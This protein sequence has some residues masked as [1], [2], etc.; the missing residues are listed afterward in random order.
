VVES[1]AHLAVIG[2]S[3]DRGWDGWTAHDD[4]VGAVGKAT[5]VMSSG[6]RLGGVVRGTVR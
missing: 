3:A 2:S 1:S 5:G 6:G 4:W